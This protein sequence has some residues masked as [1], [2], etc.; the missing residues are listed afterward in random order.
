MI[1]LIAHD[2]DMTEAYGTHAAGDEYVGAHDDNDDLDDDHDH[3][4][5]SYAATWAAPGAS[6]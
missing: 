5:D 4:S 6:I 2:A 3:K 1:L